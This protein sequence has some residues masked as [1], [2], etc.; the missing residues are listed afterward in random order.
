MS[1]PLVVI[2]MG[3]KSDLPHCEKIEKAVKVE[4]AFRL[5]TGSRLE[6]PAR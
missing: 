4:H 3:S 2:F 6:L 5:V 1:T